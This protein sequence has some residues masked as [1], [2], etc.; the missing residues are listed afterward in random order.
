MCPMYSIHQVQCCCVTVAWDGGALSFHCVPSPLLCP[1]SLCELGYVAL[2]RCVWRLVLRCGPVMCVR[3]DGGS[4]CLGLVRGAV[5]L[6]LGGALVVFGCWT[7]GVF[8]GV[9]GWIFGVTGAAVD[10]VW[11][12]LRDSLQAF[13]CGESLGPGSGPCSVCGGSGCPGG[14][15]VCSMECALGLGVRGL[16]VRRLSAVAPHS[17]SVPGGLGGRTS[18]RMWRG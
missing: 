9:S 17:L 18:G 7:R 3:V 6:R 16:P 8:C 11:P 15:S 4:A 14:S 13:S 12:G 10:W 1:F 5:R 2:E